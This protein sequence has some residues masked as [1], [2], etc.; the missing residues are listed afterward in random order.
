MPGVLKIIFN[1]VPL[2]SKDSS[3]SSGDSKNGTSF[4]KSPP[5]PPPTST[6]ITLYINE[7]ELHIIKYSRK[8]EANKG[9]EN[10]IL[11]AIRGAYNPN[12]QLVTVTREQHVFSRLRLDFH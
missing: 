11:Q 9:K 5:P 7:Y 8:L 3:S 2:A 6:T 1:V 12:L 10:L 4:I